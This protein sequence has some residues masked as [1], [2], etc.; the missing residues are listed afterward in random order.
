ML[1]LLAQAQAA[2]I[3]VAPSGGHHTTIQAAFDAAN[4]GDTIQVSAGTWTGGLVLTGKSVTLASDEGLEATTL[5]GAGAARLLDVQDGSLTLKG[6]TLTNDDGA[7]VLLEDATLEGSDLVFDNMGTDD[8]DGSY[9]PQDYGGSILAN[10]SAV[11]LARVVFS[12]GVA[13]DGAHI[14]GYSTSTLSVSDSTFE[15]GRAISGGSIYWSGGDVTLSGT[16]HY[17]NDAEYSG[18]AAYFTGATVSIEGATFEDNSLYSYYGAAV[19]HDDG[20]LTVSGSTFIDNLATYGY[21]GA[22]WLGSAGAATIT[23]TEF[24]GNEAYRGGGAIAAYYSYAP[25]TVTDSVFDDNYSRYGYGGGI[26]AYVQVELVLER[27]D[28]TDNRAG[29]QGG[30]LYQYYYG[31]ASL[32]DVAFRDNT[33]DI[34]SGGGAYL[35][36]V[37][38][39]STASLTDVVFEGNDAPIE[40]GGLYARYIDGLTIRQVDFF[41]NGGAEGLLGGGMFL[42]HVN[43]FSIS[44]SRFA[45]NHATYGGGF[46]ESNSDSTSSWTNVVLQENTA[47]IG[48]AGCFVDTGYTQFT[49]NTV[50]GNQAIEEASALCLYEAQHDFINNVFA[51]NLGAAAFHGYDLNSGFY[52]TFANNDWYGNDELVAGELV[53]QE[54]FGDGSLEVDPQLVGWTADGDADN[55]ALMLQADSPL[56]DAGHILYVDPDGS[57]ADIG[58]FGGPDAPDGD[59]DGD[60]FPA[61]QDCDDTDASVHPGAADEWYDGIDSDCGGEAD[62]DADG[63]GVSE[64]E[65]CDDTDPALTDDCPEPEDTDVP[66]DDD[67]LPA[68]PGTC[69]TVPFG[70]LWFLGLLVLRRR[71]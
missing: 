1:L 57:P 58:A 42:N 44:R 16:E 69:S 27:V 2:T 31:S 15:G 67:K 45:N 25:L 71:R 14:A 35:Y 8:E 49:N 56:V 54:W 62:D 48:G 10:G 37:W 68:D 52:S 4:S 33:A 66:E 39:G 43:T 6:F 13:E 19:F 51:H 36:Y 41:D 32:T 55:D 29:Y 40:G 59:E 47:R 61:W 24:V 38:T 60:G 23:D 34:Y 50:L 30:G 28:F 70:G 63:D 21:G 64:L 17:T 9:F 22:M 26:W 5:D 12:G 18:G 65:D 3:V 20:E 11:Y 46:Y 7:G 53:D